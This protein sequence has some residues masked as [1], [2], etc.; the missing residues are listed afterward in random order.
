MSDL[1]SPTATGH[2]TTDAPQTSH[3]PAWTPALER[4]Q[5]SRIVAFARW[6]NA[7]GRAHLD[8][9]LD[10][11]ELQA[12]SADQ[13]GD[14]WAAVADFFDVPFHDRADTVLAS[15]DMPG[16]SWFPGAT[17]NIVE[18]LLSHRGDSTAIVYARED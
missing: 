17:M 2:V 10:Y 9:P 8:D 14:F 11:A 18:R 16:A 5:A 1:S 3:S 7:T 6:L 15:T 13:T 4:V 12:W